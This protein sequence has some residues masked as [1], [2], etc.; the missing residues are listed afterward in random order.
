MRKTALLLLLLFTGLSSQA[1]NK[2]WTCINEDGDDIFSIEAI[3]VGD[4]HN[5]L[6]VVYKNTLVNNQWVT[7]NG[8]VNMRGEIIIPCDLDKAQDF[9]ADVAWIK[10]EDEAFYCLIDKTGKVLP[11][12]KYEKVGTFF[13]SD[14]KRCA[15]YEDGKMGFVDEKGNEVIPCKYLGSSSS[16]FSEGL[17]SVALASSIKGEYGFI[18]RDGEVVI[19][20][21]FIQ[22]G[23]SSFR[24]GLTR[25][26]IAGKT[27]LIDKEGSIAFSTK[28]GN[29]Q[30]AHNGLILVITKSNR[31][32]WGWVNSQDEFVINPIYDY[33]INF[34]EDGYAVVEKNDL[35]GMID[36]SGKVILPLKYETIY[37]NISKDGYF[38]GVYPSTGG[39]SLANAKKD[40][41]DADLNIIPL[42][43][44]KYLMGA[45]KGNRIA[46]ANASGKMGY[47]D[48]KYQIVIP[49]LFA[50][51]KT[52]S[53]GL[54][55]VRH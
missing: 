47:M 19:P 7:G 30:G 55:W 49:P 18:N 23:T 28:N 8:Y 46:F 29:I 42:E 20:L 48:R 3:Y 6:A 13:E 44:V 52:F 51:V 26:T 1:K 27:V 43:N 50:K 39:T 45:D 24:N 22:S 12:K 10:R 14:L 4:F 33:A 32:G 37:C 35:K 41:F 40:Y 25:A 11:T 16:S 34:N 17:A 36:S 9:K 54:S 21:K 53:E 2:T 31:T 38:C 5:G 15:V